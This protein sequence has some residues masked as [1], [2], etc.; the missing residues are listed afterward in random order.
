[1]KNNNLIKSL[2]LITTVLIGTV[3][4][5]G[6]AEV[7]Q[8]VTT[9][10][11]PSVAI[12][13]ISSNESGSIN[14]ATGTNTGL[15]ASFQIQ[16]NGTD[17]DYDF[18]VT[19]SILTLENGTVSA[20]GQNGCLL[21]GNITNPPTITAIENARLGGNDNRNVIA[22]PVTMG[23]T[24]PMSVDFQN[25]ATYGDCWVVKVNTGAEGTLT[26]TVGQN[27]FGNTYSVG[28]DEAGSYQATVTF[29]AVS[30]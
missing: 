11:Q 22:Y 10:V 16:T 30:K 7:E 19:S 3:Q 1:M 12:S 26:Q 21:F 27:P 15:S 13:K 24:S 25:N 14:P 6:Y 20:Y 18:I 5:Y 9:D 8:S 17:D 29:T 23:I 4:A 2:I 28:Q